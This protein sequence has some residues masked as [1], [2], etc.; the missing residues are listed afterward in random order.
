MVLTEGMQNLRLDG[1]LT[2]IAITHRNVGGLINST[3]YPKQMMK[4]VKKFDKNGHGLLD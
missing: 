1:L 3:H 4:N 2:I